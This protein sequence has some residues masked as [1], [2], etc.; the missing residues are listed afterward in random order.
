LQIDQ[1]GYRISVQPR[2]HKALDA[3]PPGDNAT[4]IWGGFVIFG[5]LKI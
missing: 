4:P 3:G 5:V 1:S 2:L